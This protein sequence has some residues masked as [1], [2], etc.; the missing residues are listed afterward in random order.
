VEVTEDDDL[1]SIVPTIIRITVTVGLNTNRSSSPSAHPCVQEQ[2]IALYQW[3]TDRNTKGAFTLRAVRRSKA[4][5]VCAPSAPHGAARRWIIMLY[6]VHTESS[7]R[8]APHCADFAAL[9]APVSI[10]L[11]DAAPCG[12]VRR[13]VWMPLKER[14]NLQQNIFK[15]P[16][17][18]S[19]QMAAIH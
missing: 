6:V 8:T 14:Y 9:I 4:A 15:L 18:S 13:A 19:D 3:S 2:T 11:F 10:S 16:I 7:N 12:A 17:A 5:P 1:T